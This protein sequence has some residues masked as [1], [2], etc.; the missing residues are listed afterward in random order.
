MDRELL[1]LL[2]RLEQAAGRTGA[3]AR[4]ASGVA[5]AVCF[6]AGGA[7]GFVLWHWWIAA[8]CAAAGVSLMVGTERVVKALPAGDMRPVVD[9][10]RW[11]PERI[12]SVRHFAAPDAHWLE[13]KTA[14]SRLVLD[15][16]ADWERLLR[17][18]QRR[19]PGAD[20][21]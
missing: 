15:A 14:D 7:F 5:A 4:D 1:Y 2:Y 3:L 16:S 9:A 20:Y 6:L 8:L 19:C 12:S 17:A 10:V 18:L 21:A 13:V 11:A